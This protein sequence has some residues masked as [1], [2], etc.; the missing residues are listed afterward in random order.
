V[1]QM[2]LIGLHTARAGL[3]LAQAVK[4]SGPLRR[5][6][7]WLLGLRPMRTSGNGRGPVFT[8]G[9]KEKSKNSG[10]E[11]LLLII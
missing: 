1:G 4:V 9:P 7:R 2:G 10:E 3:L 6:G 11:C 8:S 5:P